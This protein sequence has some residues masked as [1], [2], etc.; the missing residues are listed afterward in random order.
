MQ[1]SPLCRE[2]ILHSAQLK[3]RCVTAALLVPHIVTLCQNRMLPAI[4]GLLLWYIF[5]VVANSGWD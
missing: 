2:C 3:Q 1:L 5:V 4:T